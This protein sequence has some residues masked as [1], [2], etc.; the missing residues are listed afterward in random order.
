MCV[1]T[2]LSSLDTKNLLTFE[3][4]RAAGALLFLECLFT[5]Y[6]RGT[7]S[8]GLLH[9]RPRQALSICLLHI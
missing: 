1:R 8:V 2:G 6:D 5:T 3:D 7:L 9:T 4:A